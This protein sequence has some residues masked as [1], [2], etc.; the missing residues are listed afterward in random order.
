MTATTGWDA[1]T[2]WVRGTHG[3][4]GLGSPS[5]AAP[6]LLP[7]NFIALANRDDHDALFSIEEVLLLLLPSVHSYSIVLSSMWSITNDISLNIPEHNLG[8]RPSTMNETK[9]IWLKSS[10]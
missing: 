6:P 1:A 2:R 4:S 8:S 3:S 5:P 10:T 7:P 9:M